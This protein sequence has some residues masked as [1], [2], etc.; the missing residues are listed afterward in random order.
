MQAVMCILASGSRSLSYFFGL[1]VIG[2]AIST[3]WTTL[4]AQEIAQWA[5]RDLGAIFLGLFGMLV[6]V[7]LFCWTRMLECA[8]DPRGRLVWVDSGLHAAN[9]IS[10]LALTYTLLGISLGIGTLAHQNLTPESVQSIIRSLTEHFSLAFMTTVIGLPT[11]AVMR[12]LI[13]ITATRLDASQI[14]LSRN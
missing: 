13:G 12:A 4:E 5:L 2:F 14:I 7:G 8:S 1:C 3:G 10:T 6:F 9:G 11:A